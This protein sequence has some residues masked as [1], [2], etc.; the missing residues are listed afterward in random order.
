MKEL[1]KWVTT[2]GAVGALL[3]GTMAYYITAEVNNTQLT[4]QSQIDVIQVKQQEDAGM[5]KVV[6]Q[7]DKRL[8]NIETS[9]KNQERVM[10]EVQNL[11]QEI[12]NIK[13]EMAR[14]GK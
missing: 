9:M 2:L 10:A 8:S 3:W 4:L 14:G 1:H 11:E 13:V 6:I 5:N 7:I 12:N